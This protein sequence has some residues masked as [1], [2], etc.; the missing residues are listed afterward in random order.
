MSSGGG[1][2]VR[3][4]YDSSCP[5]AFL[6][7]FLPGYGILQLL[8]R[9]PPLPPSSRILLVDNP[10]STG[11]EKARGDPKKRCLRADF[12]LFPP[13][14]QERSAMELEVAGPGKCRSL[15]LLRAFHATD[16]MRQSISERRQQEPYRFDVS[17]RYFRGIFRGTPIVPRAEMRR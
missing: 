10:D 8:P 13:G 7:F 9:R 3:W 2:S 1:V 14:S 17:W 12:P 6:R 5:P 11:G 15:S 4:R 16:I